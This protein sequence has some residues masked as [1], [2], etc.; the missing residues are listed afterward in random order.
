[1]ENVHSL[2]N[3]AWVTENAVNL[4]EYFDKYKELLDVG[5]GR[6]Y[7]EKVRR[8]EAIQEFF[9]PRC[10][11]DIKESGD[12][13]PFSKEGELDD[14]DCRPESSTCDLQKMEADCSIDLLTV[15]DELITDDDHITGEAVR[16]SGSLTNWYAGSFED[17]II[18]TSGRETLQTLQEQAHELHLRDSV[19]D[20]ARL[21][22][23]LLKYFSTIRMITDENNHPQPTRQDKEYTIESMR[24]IVLNVRI[25][26]P[27]HK[28]THMKKASNRFPS[29]SQEL[30]LL[31]SQKLTELRDALICINDL[32]VN[33]DLSIDPQIYHLSH[34]PNNSVMFPSGFFYINGVIYNDTRH[35][36]AKLYSDNVIKWSK[37][38]PEV[39]ELKAKV[40]HETRFID[41][42]LR[43]GFPYVYMHQGNCE[44]L[45]VFT[46]VRL[47]H[48]N[49]SQ[50]PARYPML[51]GQASKLAVKCYICSLN[52]A[53][54]IVMNE[55][56]IPVPNAHVCDRCLKQFCYTARGTKVLPN[57]RV[58]P[59]IDEFLSQQKKEFKNIN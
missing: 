38:H 23:R 47:H 32:G 24:D 12:S 55:S 28:K 42:E 17:G 46:D 8:D 50:D 1:M 56:R 36:D 10:K 57:I 21:R 15:D 45:I 39:G 19:R 40:M 26:R 41:L 27:Y 58:Y 51:R 54:W 31:G 35:P 43:L 13:S 9:P 34:L 48:Q 6:P 16:H 22:Y 4:K 30:L 7:H 14:I 49:D 25:Q 52:L 18:P 29:H 5:F 53:N 59:F 11:E 37:R 2:K 33:Q 3:C 44:H 20:Y